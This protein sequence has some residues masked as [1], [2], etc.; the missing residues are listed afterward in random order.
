MNRKYIVIL[1][2]FLIIILSVFASMISNKILLSNNFDK[3]G[4]NIAKFNQILKYISNYYVD[5][6]DWEDSMEGAINGLLSKLDPHSLYIPITEAQINEENFQGKYQ[7]IGIYF[8]IINGYITVIAPIPGSP[9]YKIGLM[10]GDKI[11]K[12]NGESVYNISNNEVQK[13]LKGPKGS[14]VNIDV[15]RSTLK[16]PLHFTIIRDEIPIHSINSS[17]VI[18]DKIGYIS[19]NR[20]AMNTANEV[21]DALIKLEEQGIKRLILD[22][23][24]NAGGYLDQAVKLTAKF[25]EGHKLV[26]STKGRLSYFNEDYY[27]DSYGLNNVR[28]YPLIIL[29]DHTSASA[30]EIL[31]GAIQDYDR[32]LIVGTTSFGKG[33][34][35]REFTLD[36]ESKLRL[37]ISKYYTPSGRLIQKPYKGKEL[38]DYFSDFSDSLKTENNIDSLVKKQVY[39]TV[40]GRPVY[41]SGGITPDSVIQGRDLT[42]LSAFSIKLLEKRL[43]FEFASKYA[44][45]HQYLN[46]SFNE[47]LESF[48][49]NDLLLNQFKNFVRQKDV[50]FRKDDYRND[51]QFIKQSL[52]AEI[53]RSLWDNEKYYQVRI[54]DDYQFKEAIKLFPLAEKLLKK[55]A[56]GAVK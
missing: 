48:R 25:I 36:D 16:D 40:S 12:I 20:F 7:G 54:M 18:G 41:A 35:Q 50:H 32:G 15:V 43:F 56:V 46:K 45:K 44:Q 30:S 6:I 3:K 34:V 19:V 55:Y 26:V 42:N 53:A 2:I 52:K 1:N 49:V 27:T 51:I 5:T 8:E 33:L 22:L 24:G 10:S 13:K 31:A 4:K 9:S 14:K 17:F 37:T 47:Y 38:Y 39:Y 21:E 29:I 11:I 28:N 23:R